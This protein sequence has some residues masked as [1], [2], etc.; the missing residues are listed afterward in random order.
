MQ[1][2]TGWQAAISMDSLKNSH[3]VSQDVTRNSQIDELFDAISYNKVS[4][5]KRDSID[6]LGFVHSSF[7]LMFHL[8]EIFLF[9]SSPYQSKSNTNLKSKH[10]PFM[11]FMLFDLVLGKQSQ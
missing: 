11:P 1:L 5:L 6:F 3:P 8:N 9:L 10:M 4:Y 7:C 2:P